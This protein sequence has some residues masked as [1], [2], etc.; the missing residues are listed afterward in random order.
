MGTDSETFI[1]PDYLYKAE[2][3]NCATYPLALMKQN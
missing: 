2:I 1:L 3:L